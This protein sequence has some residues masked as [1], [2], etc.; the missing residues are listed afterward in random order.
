MS[1]AS[2]EQLVEDYNVTRVGAG[3][4]L[5]NLSGGVTYLAETDGMVVGWNGSGTRYLYA[6]SNPSPSTIVSQAYADAG[7][8]GDFAAVMGMV[9]KGQYWQVTTGTCS[10]M[11]FGV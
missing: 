2:S 1:Q 4:P 11:P 5:Y 3:T 8:G 10:W 9:R 6:D 7:G